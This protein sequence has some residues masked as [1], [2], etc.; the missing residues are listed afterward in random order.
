MACGLPEASSV[1]AREAFRAPVAVGSNVTLIVQFDPAASVAGLA[2]QVLVCAK[3]PLFAPVIAMPVIA[4][5]ALPVLV[6][7]TLCTVLVVPTG[8]PL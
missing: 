3:S 6:K 1:T 2:G 4:S 5:A 8:C 7:V